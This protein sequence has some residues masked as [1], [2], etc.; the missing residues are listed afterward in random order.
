LYSF[1]TMATKEY[2]VASLLQIYFSGP[3]LR[4]D[5]RATRIDGVLAT[6]WFIRLCCPFCKCE[7]AC[8]ICTMQFVITLSTAWPSNWG[9]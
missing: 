8:V 1:K 3:A 5:F 9:R 6:V 2:T 4:K 7:L